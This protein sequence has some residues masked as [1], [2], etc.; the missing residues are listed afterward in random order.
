MKRDMTFNTFINTYLG[1]ATQY[2]Y[3]DG[4][5]TVQCVDLAK[6][7]CDY[8]LGINRGY[9]KQHKLWAWGNARDWYES[10]NSHEALTAKTIR[11]KNTSSF[12]PIRG[13]IFVWTMNTKEGHIAICDGVGGTKEFY[14]YDQNWGGKEMKRCRHDY[15]TALGVIRPKREVKSAVN[16]RNKPSL[17]GSKILGELKKG[18]IVDVYEL[19]SDK[20]WA[21]IGKD[22]WISY[23]YLYEL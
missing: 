6:M 12:V 15:K 4:V 18:T 2:D 11:I 20:K 19:S 13:D 3:Q 16:V 22:R 14:T 21:R 10:F 17:S 1:K 7:Y 5:K 9:G 23:N 8:C